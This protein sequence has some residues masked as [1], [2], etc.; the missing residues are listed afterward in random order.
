MVGFFFLSFFLANKE[1]ARSR[2]ALVLPQLPFSLVHG[3]EGEWESWRK[4]VCGSYAGTSRPDPWGGAA[5]A[6]IASPSPPPRSFLE[7]LLL[8]LASGNRSL[9]SSSSDRLPW[10]T[11]TGGGGFDG[12]FSPPSISSLERWIDCCSY[13]TP[14]LSVAMVAKGRRGIEDAAAFSNLPPQGICKLRRSS[15]DHLHPLHRPSPPGQQINQGIGSGV[16]MFNL[17]REALILCPTMARIMPE[18][19]VAAAPARSLDAAGLDRVFIFLSGSCLQKWKT[20]L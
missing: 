5:S 7:S 3:D 17:Q 4:L 16:H 6:V 15:L 14:L 2:S 20:C 9:S 10:R 13:S 19:V 1:A 8:M 18:M 12:G 11:A